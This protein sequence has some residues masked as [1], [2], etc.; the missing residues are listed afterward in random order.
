MAIMQ[1]LEE[2][3]SSGALRPIDLELVRW[4]VSHDDDVV[5]DVALAVA[6]LCRVA[7]EGDSW[8]DLEQGQGT[9]LLASEDDAFAGIAAPESVEQWVTQL[10]A[11]KCTD[12]AGPLILRGSRLTLRQ[13]DE[14]ECRVAQ[15]LV[16][17]TSGESLIGAKSV[18]AALQSVGPALFPSTEQSS[19][20][21][22]KVAAAL[23]CRSPLTV[24]TGGPGTG[25][26]YTIVRLMALLDHVVER[27]GGKPLHI[28][29]AAPT[30]KAAAR[31]TDSLRSG[32]AELA[33]SVALR[34]E[35]PEA[36]TLHRLL[37]IHRGLDEPLRARPD[38]L[39][40]DLIIVDECSML[41]LAM[42]H[43][44]LS[45]IRRDARLVLLGDHQQLA[46]VGLGNTLGDVVACG[47]GNRFGMRATAWLDAVGFAGCEVSP[48]PLSDCVVHLTRSRRFADDNDL[49]ALVSV[50]R[51][52]SADRL[53]EALAAFEGSPLIEWCDPSKQAFDEWLQAYL[54]DWVDACGQSND[55]V[56]Q[57]LGQLRQRCI[58][59]AVRDGPWGSIGINDAL[60]KRLGRRRIPRPILITS[61]D[62]RM[63]I[64]NGDLGVHWPLRREAWFEFGAEPRMLR[65]STLPPHE[66][67]WAITTH[68][69]QG[70]EFNHVDVVLPDKAG[71]ILTRSL[72]YTAISR[73]RNSVRIWG[74][75]RVIRACLEGEGRKC[76][77]LVDRL[78]RGEP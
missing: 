45:S 4:I 6:W 20:D 43:R 60:L 54:D 18:G 58:L 53:I 62:H 48:E 49:G 47:G 32:V 17:R 30:G 71:P 73:A 24:I 74:T 51:S 35:L 34:T 64:Y 57:V 15:D 44:L 3:V 13:V 41:D 70:S 63:S 42:L 61:N 78:A 25:K 46:S 66:L 12:E 8:V 67:A 26:T 2:A 1:Q 52:D 50:V 65:P 27:S 69:S 38:K 31:V 39:P 5:D 72:L 14:L 23:A 36:T 77:G 40:Y 33:Q 76:G 9:V 11:S 16:A 28:A 56:A 37:G 19:T 55:D 21:W 75:E 10:A 59:T 7:G 22:Q 29:L 68:K